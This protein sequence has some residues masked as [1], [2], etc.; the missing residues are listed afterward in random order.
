MDKNYYK[1]Y[2][3]L[4]RTHWWFKARGEILLMHLRPYC[5]GRAALKILN[6]GAATGRTSELLAE[7]G[8]VRSIEYDRECFEFTRQRLSMPIEQGSI[9]DLPYPDHTFDLVCAF[10]VLEHVHDDQR[11]AAELERVCKPGGMVCVTVPAF[12]FL[13]SKHDDVNHHFRRYTRPQLSQLFNARLQ[14]VYHTYFNGWLFLPIAAFRLLAPLWPFRRAKR[15]D[16]GSDFFVAKGSWTQRLFYRIFRS[17]RFFVRR[18]IPLPFGVSILS[19][20]RKSA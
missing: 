9:L 15:E 20:W 19:S 11:A 10:D 1:E 14:P 7:F 12:M 2:Y 6:V 18:R 17:E 16:A 5:Q 13:W 8:D 4:E 3:E